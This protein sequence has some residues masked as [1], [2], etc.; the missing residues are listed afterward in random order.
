MVVMEEGNLPHPR[1][2]RCGIME[3]WEALNKRHTTTTQEMWEITERAFQA[4]SRPLKLAIS[5][6]YLVCIMT[7]SNYGCP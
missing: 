4:Y 6:K 5:F 1:C 3:P 7:A 2:P